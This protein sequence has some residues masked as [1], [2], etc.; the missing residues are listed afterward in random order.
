MTKQRSKKQRQRQT[1]AQFSVRLSPEALAYFQDMHHAYAEWAG[2]GAHSNYA[3]LEGFLSALLEGYPTLC[4]K[5]D[6]A[7]ES[8]ERQGDDLKYL[9]AKLA[10]AGGEIFRVIPVDEARRRMAAGGGG[11]APAG[12]GLPN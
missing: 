2:A 10:E 12:G 9:A 11:M 7:L 6:D 5:Y 4:M 3:N 8:I 1:D